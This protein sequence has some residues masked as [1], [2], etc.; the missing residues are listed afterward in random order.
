MLQLNRQFVQ[1]A[2]TVDRHAH[3]SPTAKQTESN[4]RS[5]SS[6]LAA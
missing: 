5:D 3:A 4:S 1:L 2:L 6:A